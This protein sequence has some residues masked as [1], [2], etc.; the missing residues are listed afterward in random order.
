[1][2]TDETDLGILG[3]LQQDARMPFQTIAKKVGVSDATVY[4]RVQKMK[5]KGIIKRFTADIDEK[6]LGK[7][8]L[9]C[10]GFNV[11]AQHFNEVL[12]KLTESDHL[13]EVWTTTGAHNITA[14]GVFRDFS[15]IQQFTQWLNTL[16]GL[17]RFD[18]TMVVAESKTR[19]RIVIGSGAESK[20]TRKNKKNR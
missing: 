7:G 9:V 12:G 19:P 20:K 11:A 2:E 5:K 13:H 15:D 4:N 18:F 17:D 8:V 3:C 1:M 16:H 10:M 14:R 6:K